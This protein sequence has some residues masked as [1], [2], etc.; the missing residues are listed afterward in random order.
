MI[1]I[2]WSQWFWT[3]AG[4]RRCDIRSDVQCHVCSDVR[5]KVM[6]PMSCWY[7]D[8]RLKSFKSRNNF[9]SRMSPIYAEARKFSNW[10]HEK[11]G[12]NF[13]NGN[14]NYKNNFFY[15][16]W[17]GITKKSP[18]DRAA[19]VPF[20]KKLYYVYHYAIMTALNF[21]SP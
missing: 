15:L 9:G 12:V 11:I 3:T 17:I 6:F 20:F 8:I 13:R 7:A 14:E 19:V 1:L 16:F 18:F 21:N 2:H 4:S 5:F 10:F